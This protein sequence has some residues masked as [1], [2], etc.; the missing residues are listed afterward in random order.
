MWWMKWNK[1][2]KGNSFCSDD[3]LSKCGGEKDILKRIYDKIVVLFLCLC[4]ACLFV[5]PTSGR[6]NML[7]SVW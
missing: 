7:S 5:K 2:L 3:I 6:T 1:L 4:F